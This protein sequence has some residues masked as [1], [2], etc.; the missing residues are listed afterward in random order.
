M[1]LVHLCSKVGGQ[2]ITANT[3]Q[4]E[5]IATAQAD[6]WLNVNDFNVAIHA[7]VHA[8]NGS[9]VPSFLKMDWWYWSGAFTRYR[10]G[11]GRLRSWRRPCQSRTS[12]IFQTFRAEAWPE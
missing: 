2:E 11:R 8:S 12:M 7:R 1:V 4:E 10:A 6:R 9:H 3:F 5:L